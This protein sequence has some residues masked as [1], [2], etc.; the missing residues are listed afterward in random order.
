M[1]AEQKRIYRRNYM[2]KWIANNREKQNAYQAACKAKNPEKYA[3]AEKQY[4]ARISEKAV[5]K[6]RAWRLANP[7]RNKENKRRWNKNNLAYRCAKTAE[8]SARLKMATPGWYEWEIVELVYLE[9]AHRGLEVDHIIPLTGKTVCGLHVHTNM[10]LLTRS[11][12]ARKN[13][14]LEVTV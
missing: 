11:E 8:R 4:R 7:E 5:A 9:A 10:Q 13:N 6:S 3:A 12:N 2:R 14:R 1:N